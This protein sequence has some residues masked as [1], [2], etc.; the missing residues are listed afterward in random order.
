MRT[1]N[2][3]ECHSSVHLVACCHAR[4]QKAV[5]NRK[6]FAVCPVD[7]FSEEDDLKSHNTRLFVTGALQLKL[8][9]TM[10][11][12]AGLL[13]CNIFKFNLTRSVGK[14]I[15]KEWLYLAA[16][17]LNGVALEVNLR[18]PIPVKSC[19]LKTDILLKFNPYTLCKEKYFYPMFDW[20]PSFKVLLKI[21]LRI[22]IEVFSILY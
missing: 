22:F 3:T 21:V 8:V 18:Y 4:V 10:L 1:K 13:V 9:C 19:Y 7:Q 20:F 5:V 12:M 16:M 17:R 2:D 6:C 11:F 15:F 14:A